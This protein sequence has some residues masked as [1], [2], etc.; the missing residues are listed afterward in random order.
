MDTPRSRT[1]SFPSAYSSTPS[2]TSRTQTVSPGSTSTRSATP[3]SSICDCQTWKGTLGCRWKSACKVAIFSS[4]IPPHVPLIRITK[5]ETFGLIITLCGF[6]N[7]DGA[8]SLTTFVGLDLI[9]ALSPPQK[10]ID[11]SLHK[12]VRT[13]FDFTLRPNICC[14]IYVYDNK[15]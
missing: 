12:L 1:T 15:Q 7:A 3:C 10:R 13:S 8:S 14:F 4:Y 5:L 9:A 2:K 11:E 6:L